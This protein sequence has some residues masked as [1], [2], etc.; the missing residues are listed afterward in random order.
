M[1]ILK[2]KSDLFKRLL[3][4]KKFVTIGALLMHFIFSLTYLLFFISLLKNLPLYLIAIIGLPML[5]VIWHKAYQISYDFKLLF[6][7]NDEY[8]KQVDFPKKEKRTTISFVVPSYQEPFKVAKMTFDSIVNAPFTGKKEIIVVDNSNDK[9]TED[10]INWRNYV[11]NFNL[12]YP[13]RGIRAKFLYNDEKNTLKPG[14]LD[15]AQRFIDEG[16]LVVFMDV[17]ST[18]PDSGNLLERAVAEF[19]ADNKLGFLQFRIRATN[20]H[21][22][23]LTQAVAVSQYLFRL[24]MISRGYGGY[25][26]FEGHNGIWRKTILDELGSWTNYYKGDVIITED[27]LKTAQMYAVG[28]YGK[29]LN[30]ETGE[31]VPSSLKALDSM[32]MRWMY[33]NCQVL[34]KYFGKIY[35]KQTSLVEKFDISHHILHHVATTLFFLV[36]FSLQLLVKGAATNIYILSTFIVPQLI[37]AITSYFIGGS[38]RDLPIIKKIKHTYDGFF[39]VETFIMF[40]QF[41]SIVKFILRVRQGWNVTEK[42]I[43]NITDWKSHIHNNSFHISMAI[44]STGICAISWIFNY[45]MTFHSLFYH[46]GLLFVNVSLLS[47]I[48][49]FGRKGRKSDNNVESE[50]VICKSRVA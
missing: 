5:F 31:W 30:V 17:D 6:L 3:I 13:N 38:K 39:L 37:G 41:K 26:I 8:D 19:E 47:C 22:N 16:E 20:D 14:N 27:I 42:G 48:I 28:Y 43:E 32:W 15:L 18:L 25:K 45:R 24:R 50:I 7:F 49:S 23:S 11:E 2:N 1:V 34:S 36:A 44:L 46:F 21:F 10:F 40:T 29:P 4:T 9:S 35:S 12:T 33:G